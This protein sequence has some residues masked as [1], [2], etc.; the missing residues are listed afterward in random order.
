M[1]REEALQK[2][3]AAVDQDYVVAIRREIHEYPEIGFD[4]PK[5]IAVVKRELDS[6]GYE[7]TEKFGISS[8]VATLNP[9]KTNFTIGIR[10]DMDALPL[11][12]KTDLPFKSKN[13]GKMHACGHDAHTAMLLGTAK[14]LKSVEDA[15]DCRVKLLFQPFE[16]GVNGAKYMVRDGVMDDIDIIIGLHVENWLESGCIGVCP[17]ESMAASTPITIEF[18]GHTAHATL[19][20]TGKDALAMA[21]SAYN[22]IQL[23]MAREMDP[24]KHWV[25]SV[26]QLSAGTTHNVIADY[27]IMKISLRTYEVELNDYIIK[28]IEQICAQ[29][30]ESFGGTYTFDGEMSA[31]PIINDPAI[32]AQVLAA[33]AKI[34]GEDKIVEMRPKLS[35]EDFSQ[36]LTKKPG[37]FFRLGTRNEAKG[38]VT[39]PHNNDFLIDEE[40]FQVGCKTCV[41]FVFDNMHGV[42][43]P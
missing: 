36:Y 26:G 31:F 15:I 7:Y 35:S 22:N 9:E 19:P 2:A 29:A 34:V 40:P 13:D 1:T 33:A 6:M 17:G 41:Q 11:Q 37:V 3:L 21:V 28:R 24:F 16:E 30:A 18:F 14:A 8:V 23:M 20:Q 4:C 27:A 32:S 10:A 42:G 43:C 39:L 25:M 5:T 38:C 12:E